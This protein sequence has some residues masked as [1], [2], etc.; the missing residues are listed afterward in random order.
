MTQVVTP[1]ETTELT[2]SQIGKAQELVGSALRKSGLSSAPFQLVLEQ[3][4][5]GIVA[6]VLAVFR[7]R[8]EAISNLIVR[9]AKVNRSRKPDETLKATGRKVYANNDV[10][11]AMPRGA[12]NDAEVIFFKLDLAGG[13]I[14]DNNLEKEY[15]LRGLKPADPYSLAAV[16]EDDLAFT[17]DHPNSTHWKDANDRWCYAAFRRWRDDERRVDVRRDDGGWRDDWWFAGLRK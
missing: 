16:N 13:Y 17:D 7:K 9:H 14:T 5:D 1:S 15:E 11:K 3:Q 6:D 4:G 8:V 10:V 2:P 12:G